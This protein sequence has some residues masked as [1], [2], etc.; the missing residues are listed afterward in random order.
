MFDEIISVTSRE[1]VREIKNI[2]YLLCEHVDWVVVTENIVLWKY[3][4]KNTIK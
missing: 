3:V 4:I 2:S 1:N